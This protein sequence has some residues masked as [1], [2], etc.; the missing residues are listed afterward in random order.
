M[1]VRWILKNKPKIKDSYIIFDLSDDYSPEIQESSYS[2]IEV[3]L[4]A[5]DKE[6]NDNLV[7]FIGDVEIQLFSYIEDD[8]RTVLRSYPL[9]MQKDDVKRGNKYERIFFNYFGQSEI[10]LSS[11]NDH[12]LLLSKTVDITMHK[13][14]ATS[15][16]E[17]LDYLSKNVD[18]ILLLCF[19][20]TKGGVVSEK[21]A[22]DKITQFEILKE[23]IRIL[24]KDHF[25][26][27]RKHK[28]TLE[29]ELIPS[30]LSKDFSD[31]SNQW[32]MNNLDLACKSSIDDA[33]MIINKFQTYSIDNIPS[34]SLKIDTN[35][36]ENQAL[37]SFFKRARQFLVSLKRTFESE[38]FAID[39]MNKGD[40]VTEFVRFDSVLNKFKVPVLEKKTVEVSRLLLSINK[41][42]R[43]FSKYLPAKSSKFIAPKFNSFVLA[44]KHYKIAFHH[45][46]KFYNETNPIRDDNSILMGLRNL[47]Q[48]YEFTALFGI[49]NTIKAGG[50]TLEYGSEHCFSNSSFDGLA[51]EE[52]SRDELNNVY[53]FSNNNSPKH[54]LKL[55][56]EPQVN[57]INGN[58]REGDL[59]R[60]R[61]YSGSEY[62]YYC[63]DYVV[64]K[65]HADDLS[66][67]DVFIF[68]AKFSAVETVRKFQFDKLT[69]NYLLGVQEVST[70]D[71][72]KSTVKY[73][74]LLCAQKY[75][76]NHHRLV[77]NTHFVTGKQPIYPQISAEYYNP[78]KDE[79]LNGVFN[80]LFSIE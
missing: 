50:Y 3:E 72:L 13:D 49:L 34:E 77:E 46:A 57:C 14:K 76:S 7:V 27:I 33:N 44:N 61:K 10:S 15:A 73:V 42:S 66:N 17:M 18:D 35:N 19:S 56:Y 11:K 60:I 36:M 37:Y 21:G 31:K 24:E 39:N 78:A 75:Q 2:V 64:R 32:I 65:Y 20:K 62:K 12:S 41:L 52:K 47:S 28:N 68:D 29:K 8:D 80:T 22:N 67:N 55:M 38:K 70:N 5:L 23:T 4:S 53:I 69:H 6:L 71:R 40:G 9:T 59:V 1:P 79:H 74:G 54:K 51:I 30:K 58:S 43:I 63:P 45:I 16:T 25:L 48:I 26:F